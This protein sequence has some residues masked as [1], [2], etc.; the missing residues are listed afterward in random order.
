VREEELK[1]RVGAAEDLDRMARRLGPPARV[2]HQRNVYFDTEDLALH[3]AGALVRLRR[4]AGAAGGLLTVKI[5]ERIE[6]GFI[7]ARED[8]RAVGEAEAAAL[9][10][11]PDA[12]LRACCGLDLAPEALARAG[13]RPLGVAGELCTH[14]RSFAVPAG[15]LALDVVALTGRTEYEIE[16][17]T[18]DRAAGT[19]FL[20]GLL[21]RLGIAAWKESEPKT[22][23]LF[24]RTIRNPGD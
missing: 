4:C 8:E 19:A 15:S 17:E 13:G 24:R 11:A 5:A 9:L 18:A 1:Y 16:L 3:R 22:G 10:A 20:E 7:A 2:E 14:R 21:A 23:R 12:W 6:S